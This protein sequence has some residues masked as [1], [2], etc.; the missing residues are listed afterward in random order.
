[1]IAGFD[2]QLPRQF[3]LSGRVIIEG[4][5][6]LPPLNV[7]VARA[8]GVVIYGSGSN[9]AAVRPPGVFKTTVTEGE[10]HVTIEGLPPTYVLKSMLSGA[11]DL[12]KANLKIAD[13][14]PPEIVVTL[15]SSPPAVR[16]LGG[17][18][19]GDTNTTPPLRV[20]IAS[21]NFFG[22][23]STDVKSDGS[24]EFPDVVPGTYVMG[25]AAGLTFSAGTEVLVA[26]KDITNLEL[27]VPR[28]VGVGLRVSVDGD[29]R[30]SNFPVVFLEIRQKDGRG[31]VAINAVDPIDIPL[32]EGD[33]DLAIRALPFGYMLKS[34]TYGTTDLQ[35]NEL[36][37]T[38]PSTLPIRIVLSVQPADAAAG[39]KIAGKAT[40]NFS[41]G[42]PQRVILRSVNADDPNAPGPQATNQTAVK[43]DGSFQFEKVP[44]GTYLASLMT[45]PPDEA[46]R[47]V[48]GSKD[49]TGVELVGKQM[50]EVYGSVVFEGEQ[51]TTNRPQ[52]VVTATQL[53]IAPDGN[54]DFAAS[55]ET[56]GAR[57]NP[58]GKFKLILRTGDSRIAVMSPG[59]Y[60]VKSIVFG[61]TDLNRQALRIGENFDSANAP[62]IQ[63]V[64]QAVTPQPR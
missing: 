48:V 19:L 38:N 58:D 24:F 2:I 50:A 28:P 17:K 4:G 25:V 43:I 12:T 47:I 13:V 23:R 52:I 15:T 29:S 36:H 60:R 9:Y 35:T 1:D 62:S 16:R 31:G 53:R 59:G 56:I 41:I 64:L 46:I 18:V 39:V 6:P 20:F 34:F 26:D 27:A 63:I 49:V 21:P 3:E 51:Q 11:V 33:Y 8:N 32:V 14:V 42:G 37:V 44:P 7:N 30:P 55:G 40:G 10:Y 5:A 61:D 22:N 57:V 54:P 45:M